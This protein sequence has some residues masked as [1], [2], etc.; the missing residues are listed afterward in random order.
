MLSFL[1]AVTFHR[2]EKAA[3]LCHNFK[4]FADGKVYKGSSPVI[5]FFQGSFLQSA[6]VIMKVASCSLFALLAC[7]VHAV[8][9]PHDEVTAIEHFM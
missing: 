3:S 2:P 8:P 7:L 9:I 6:R 1:Q 5:S 4:F